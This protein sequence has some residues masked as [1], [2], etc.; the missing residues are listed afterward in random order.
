MSAGSFRL[1]GW[2]KMWSTERILE[3]YND[4]LSHLRVLFLVVYSEGAWRADQDVGA[5]FSK[6]T[7]SAKNNG[8]SQPT[9]QPQPLEKSKN[10]TK[11]PD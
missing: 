10:Q 3:I 9:T 1:T 11:T 4:G 5:S 6:I 7:Q 2:R 8:T